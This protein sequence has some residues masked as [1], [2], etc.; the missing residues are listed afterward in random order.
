[1][2]T[3]PPKPPSLFDDAC[4]VFSPLVNSHGHRFWMG[5]WGYLLIATASGHPRGVERSSEVRSR[6]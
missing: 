6:A 1:M 2:A 5:W 4:L 3:E